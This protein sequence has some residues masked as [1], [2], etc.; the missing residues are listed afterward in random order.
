MG[1]RTP[2]AD[3]LALLKEIAEEIRLYGFPQLPGSL[4]SF[5]KTRT[6]AIV[7]DTL[8]QLARQNL[9]KKHEVELAQ[10]R[11][12]N[13]RDDMQLA[14]DAILQEESKPRVW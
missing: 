6:A 10:Q 7:A 1:H 9:D 3:D 12:D 14:T 4:R 8:E 5:L 2:A 11:V 13:L